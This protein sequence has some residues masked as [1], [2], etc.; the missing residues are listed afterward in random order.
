MFAI[1][2]AESLLIVFLLDLM[3]LDLVR[4][5]KMFAFLGI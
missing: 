3:L 2:P 1:F 4:T 5:C